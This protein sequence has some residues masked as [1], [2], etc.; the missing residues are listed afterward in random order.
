M[1]KLNVQRETTGKSLFNT[2]FVFQNI[3]FHEIRH[4]ECTF[5]V[6]ERN[7]GVSLYDLMLTIED[8]GQQIE[9]HFDYKPGRFTKD[10]IEQ[11]TRH[12]TAILNSLVERPE[13]TLS[14]VPMLSE[15]ERHQ[16]LTECNGT[17]TPYPHKETVYRWF[18]MQAEQSPD[19]E[20]VIFGNERY[21]YRQLNER[22]NRLAR[23]LRT[24][25]V[26]ADQFVA[27]ICPHRIELIVGI[28]AVLK[29]GGAYVPIDPEYPEN[30]IQYMLRDS[31]AEVVLTQRD[32][33]DQFPYDG[34]VVL[35]DEENSYHEE[36]SNFESD[37]DA[38]DLVYMIYTSGSTGNPKGVLIE[39]QGLADYIWWAKEVYVRGEKP[40]FH[41]TLPS[42]SI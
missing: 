3:E 42:L 27:I 37:S 23:T 41:Y 28:L 32:L 21:T 24:K 22:A 1:E 12:Y 33:L 10:T 14:S 8:A 5:K 15:T 29:A 40:T 7:P 31:R 36:H 20:A 39:H 35:L 16:L 38:H 4:N 19:H 25:G 18:E 17:K 11:I 9:M 6:K 26:Q 2:M 13:M 34:D 30:R